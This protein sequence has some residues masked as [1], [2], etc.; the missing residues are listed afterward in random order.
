MHADEEHTQSADKR[1]Y[2]KGCSRRALTTSGQGHDHGFVDGA[3]GERER[4]LDVFHC[5]WARLRR[6]ARRARGGRG[7]LGC[8]ADVHGARRMIFESCFGL[9]HVR[10]YSSRIPVETARDRSSRFT[11]DRRNCRRGFGTSTLD[12]NSTSASLPASWHQ[13]PFALSASPSAL[14][15][16]C[17][18]SPLRS[19]HAL[20]AQSTHTRRRDTLS[21]LKLCE[22]RDHR[23]R[24]P[25]DFRLPRPA[26]AVTVFAMSCTP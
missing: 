18:H 20:R 12:V 26:V 15:T 10:L 8:A 3:R 6:A 5:R 16:P 11:G 7:R 4:H 22:E 13:L 19:T 2:E 1:L 21:A 14:P 25:V 24:L 23:G 9:I 17:P